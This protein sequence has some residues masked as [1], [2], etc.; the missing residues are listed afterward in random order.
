MFI[1]DHVNRVNT[2]TWVRMNEDARK[3]VNRNQFLEEFGGNF[4][5]MVVM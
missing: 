3:M 1:K 5:E 2:P 4:V